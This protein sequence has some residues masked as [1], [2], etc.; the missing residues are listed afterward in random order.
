M[1]VSILFPLCLGGAVALSGCDQMTD[2]EVER[3]VSELDGVNVIDESGLN[4]VMIS[5]AD[6]EEAVAYFARTYE[7]NPDR[8]DVQRGYAKSLTRARRPAEAARMWTKVVENPGAT[9]DDK[10]QL[11]DALIRA[12][13]WAKAD[14]FYE[15][16]VGLTTQPARTFN[17]W[18]FSKLTR[19]EY[20]G[21]E[22]LFLDALTYDPGMF[23]AKNN[24]MMARGG[25]R[26]YDVP[27]IAM[28]QVERAQLLYTLALAAIKQGDVSMG[29]TL[30]EEAVETHPQHF[31]EAVRSLRALEA[32][33]Q[34]G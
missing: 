25:Q 34:R 2:A 21:A 5:A 4:D 17:N 6:P 11:A 16:A 23:T 1:R 31:D 8:I 7:Q 32:D 12:G 3:A 15:T 33:V 20:Q 13:D 22:K 10:V 27:A 28:T 9:S 30:L 18:G 14:S 19:G 24:L 26:K 29:K